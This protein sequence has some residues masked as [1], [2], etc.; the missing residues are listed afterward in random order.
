MV[1][2]GLHG[3]RIRV[4]LFFAVAVSFA[5]ETDESNEFLRRTGALDQVPNL[6]PSKPTPTPLKK[7]TV[8]GAKPN[9]STQNQMTMA[10]ANPAQDEDI[11]MN[12]QPGFSAPPV[13]AIPGL[14]PAGAPAIAPVPGLP[15]AA[16]KPAKRTLPKRQ[17]EEMSPKKWV[18]ESQEDEEVEEGEIIEGTQEGI[19]VRESL[20]APT[21]T[22]EDEEIAGIDTV[23]LEQPQGNWLFKRLWWERAE[24][25]YEEIR[26]LVAHILESRLPFF[27]KRADVDRIVLDPFYLQ[28]AHDR[29]ALEILLSDVADFLAQE[30]E[31]D[32]MLDEEE[33][34]LRS[35]LEAERENIEQLQKNIQAVLQFDHELDFAIS[36]LM[37]Q[38]QKAN[39]YEQEAWTLFKEIG[40]V[41]DDQKAREYVLKIKHIHRNIKEIEG[42]IKGKFTAYFDQ[43]I[44][45]IKDSVAGVTATM[46]QLTE[47]GINLSEYLK[48]LKQEDFEDEIEEDVQEVCQPKADERGFFDRWIISPVSSFF[49]AIWQGIVTVV[50]WP[51]NLIFGPTKASSQVRDV[52]EVD[53]IIQEPK[54]S[55]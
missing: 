54:A 1:S 26:M 22:D 9:S 3:K 30:A 36:T 45:T 11:E 10:P 6:M 48:K 19:Q 29:G 46:D 12:D 50:S 49:G 33:K 7:Q 21:P 27:L 42:Y 52:N 16:A 31:Q 34:T 5:Q 25:K 13:G 24:E 4:L 23:D 17:K 47:K 44:A 32:Q 2:I 18:E 14:P 55:Q 43:L 40:R 38:L 51:Y 15:P 8:K 41:L 53:V 28:V 39:E 20:P 37:E 35:Q